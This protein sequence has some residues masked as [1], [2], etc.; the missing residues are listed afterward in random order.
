MPD[1]TFY[2]EVIVENAEHAVLLLHG[3][4]FTSQTWADL[5]TLG[6]F[7]CIR[8]PC[9]VKHSLLQSLVLLLELL[10]A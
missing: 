1:G 10:V 8:D 2:Q 6:E 7:Y 3:A 9:A 4:A 5:G